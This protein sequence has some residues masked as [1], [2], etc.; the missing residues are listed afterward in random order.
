LVSNQN[1]QTCSPTTRPKPSRE[2]KK[3]QKKDVRKGRN[4]SYAFMSNILEKP[5]LDNLTLGYL[6]ARTW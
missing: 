3:K 4:E 2:K 6:G 5:N 1:P